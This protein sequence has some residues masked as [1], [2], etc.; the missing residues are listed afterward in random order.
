M[1]QGARANNRPIVIEDL[2]ALLVSR[3]L[4]PAKVKLGGREWT[5]KRDFTA[6]QIIEFWRLQN[7]GAEN[8]MVDS[9]A[10]VVGADDALAFVRMMDNIPQEM[11]VP[12]VRRLL[13]HA[14][15][16]K[17]PENGDEVEE[18]IEGESSA[19]SLES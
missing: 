4:R 11:S 3:S 5:I 18:G 16:I 10:M 7:S 9:Y 19:S 1:T 13:Q 15:I 12:V 6:E 17:R 14:G 8:S 2:D